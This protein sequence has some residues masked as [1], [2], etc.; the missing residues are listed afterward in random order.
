MIRAAHD[1]YHPLPGLPLAELPAAL[2]PDVAE[3]PRPL[4][5]PYGLATNAVAVAYVND[6][7]WVA[8]CPTDGCYGAILV[9]H[10]DPR[11]YC[12]YCFNQPAG[13]RFIPIKFPDEQTRIRIEETLLA[14][15]DPKTRHFRPQDDEDLST[16]RAENREHGIAA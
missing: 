1:E 8:N 12:P 16:L 15:P 7:R 2:H 10:H 13:N 4:E 11:F 3:R 14:R 9:S 5:R 6:S